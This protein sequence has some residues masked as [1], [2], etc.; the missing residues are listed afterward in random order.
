[1]S[2]KME[3]SQNEQQVLKFFDYQNSEAGNKKTYS[4][5]DYRC[6]A[7]LIFDWETDGRNRTSKCRKKNSKLGMEPKQ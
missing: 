2:V 6:E 7:F 5:N 4:A 3:L 1:M